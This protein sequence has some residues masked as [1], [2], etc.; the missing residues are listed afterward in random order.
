VV[1]RYYH[2]AVFLLVKVVVVTPHKE[3]PCRSVLTPTRPVSAD[4]GRGDQRDRWAA[5]PEDL[6]LS[7]GTREEAKRLTEDRGLERLAG[8]LQEGRRP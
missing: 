6:V 3:P 2:L 1:E 4:T 5:V 7:R 8:A